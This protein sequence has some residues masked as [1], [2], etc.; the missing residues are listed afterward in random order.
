M[1]RY[2]V[3]LSYDG[4]DFHG[5]QRQGSARTV[6]NE[7][8]NA[9]RALGWAGRSILSSGRTDTG[10]HARG[11][12]IVFDLDW[13]HSPATLLKAFNAHLPQDIAAREVVLTGESFHPRYDAVWRYYEYTIL[14]DLLPNPLQERYAWRIEQ[15]PDFQRLQE[16]AVSLLGKHDFRSFGAPMKK[17]GNTIREVY[18]AAWRKQANSLIFGVRANAFL[19]HMVRRMVLMQVLVGLG[20]LSVEM[21][22]RGV[23]QAEPLPPGVAPPNGLTLIEVGYQRWSRL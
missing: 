10:V 6:Q 19:Y 13:K 1:A 16:T 15:E 7:V 4:T 9:L 18:E 20:R 14:I 2:Q 23:H 11:Q 5:F 17:A 8:E 22:L 12:V 21:F 3:T